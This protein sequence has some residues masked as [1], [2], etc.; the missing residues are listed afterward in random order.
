MSDPR[1][2]LPGAP[3]GSE[4]R[5]RIS[6][7]GD[8]PIFFPQDK[9][10]V[11]QKHLLNN[12]VGQIDDLSL[13]SIL[14]FRDATKMPVLA[15]P[16]LKGAKWK[17]LLNH[18]HSNRIQVLI[19]MA[20]SDDLPLQDGEAFR[21]WLFGPSP[22]FNA[23]AA[24]LKKVADDALP[25]WAG[26][27]FDIEFIFGRVGDQN[28]E[29]KRTR[30]ADFYKAIAREIHPRIVAVVAGAKISND[31]AFHH[32]DEN[33]NELNPPFPSSD[34]ALLHDWVKITRNGDEVVSNILM[35]A[36]A[37]DAVPKIIPTK[38][39]AVPQAGVDPLAHWHRA[40]IRYGARP[41]PESAKIPRAQFQL[42]IKIAGSGKPGEPGMI[43][44]SAIDERCDLARVFEVGLALFPQG[45]SPAWP[46]I[47]TLLNTVKGAPAPGISSKEPF[48]FKI[49]DLQNA[50]RLV[51]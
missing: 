16:A 37:Y 9:N 25:G 29:Q 41:R 1:A 6:V 11:F 42:L 39:G 38:S 45:N 50:F 27:N 5:M 22:D 14:K 30:V 49:T 10:F 33:G 13:L 20:P 43:T 2:S 36:M 19:G 46:R 17:E 31:A 32:L 47:N 15:N 26:I 18:C 51:P 34:A 28:L 44:G 3:A 12:G 40:T 23:F 7:L 48:Q 24:E 35:R 4:K 8:L 21:D